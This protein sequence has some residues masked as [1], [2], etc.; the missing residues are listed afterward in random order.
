MR[1]DID[2]NIE[3]DLLRHI[4]ENLINN[5]DVL[6][7]IED[8][9]F[10]PIIIDDNDIFYHGTSSLLG[11]LIEELGDI[12]VPST[13]GIETT[14]G[15]DSVFSDRI[16]LTTSKE[17]AEKWAQDRAKVDKSHPVIFK[18][19]GK[20]INNREC[21]AFIDALSFTYPISSI[22]LKECPC[23]KAVKI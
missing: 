18:I 22:V 1:V 23:I 11:E 19:I 14:H 4:L 6:T 8:E 21:K 13:T 3:K 16:Y 7:E 20:D 9:D 15:A 12:C 5:E 2:P 10:F 17:R